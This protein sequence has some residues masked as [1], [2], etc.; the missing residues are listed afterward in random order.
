MLQEA[1]KLGLHSLYLK[2]S[3]WGFSKN[4]YKNIVFSYFL[5]DMKRLMF[6]RL[7]WGKLKLSKGVSSIEK[8]ILNFKWNNCWALHVLVAGSSVYATLHN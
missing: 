5:G 1:L 6:I 2:T 7:T 3:R 8:K 4:K